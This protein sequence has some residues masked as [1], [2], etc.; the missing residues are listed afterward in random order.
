MTTDAP[1]PARAGGPTGDGGD[2]VEGRHVQIGQVAERTALSVRTVRH[3]DDVGLITPSARSVG[4][5][6]LYTEADIAR[7]LLVRRMK[8]LGFT[9]EE[10][11]ELL[12]AVDATSATDPVTAG[13]ARERVRTYHAQALQ[14][15][16]QLRTQLAAAE[17]FADRL[18]VRA[19]AI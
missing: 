12:E 7:L 11:R 10:M 17:E 3:Y 19:G 16:A 4:G 6:R 1:G 14:R 9:L 5:F 13:Q 15:C 18:A 2:P 8:P